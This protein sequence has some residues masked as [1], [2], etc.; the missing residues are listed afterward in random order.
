M[1][2]Y[3]L[4]LK[5]ASAELGQWLSRS[6]LTEENEDLLD[7]S[8][9]LLFGDISEWVS[10][11]IALK[12]KNGTVRKITY[13]LTNYA[14]L[15]AA[16]HVLGVGC[17]FG[18]L[19]MSGFT[20][21]QILEIVK[22]IETKV[23]KMIK[24]PLNTAI[25]FFTDAMREIQNECPKDAYN[26]LDKVIDNATK[27]FHYVSGNEVDSESFAESIKAIQ[28]LIFA[29]ITRY[30]YDEER[31]CFLPF[32]TLPLNKVNLIGQT[33]E[34]YVKKSLEQKK[35][36]TTTLFSWEST[37]EQENKIQDTL[38][39]VLKICYP[40]I[41]QARGW[42]NMRTKINPNE[43]QFTIKVMPQYLPEGPEDAAKVVVG[44][45]TGADQPCS[46]LLWRTTTHIFS[47][48]GQNIRAI[49][50][51]MNESQLHARFEENLLDI[52]LCI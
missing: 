26:T 22:R 1:S 36:V 37:L 50:Y 49:T 23:D 3:E 19:D 33:L 21:A 42:T 17:G 45:K 32:P 13:F 12:N 52:N 29:K 25:D 35:N 40:Y 38:D 34:G 18:K 48:F 2:G 44:V 47:M 10:A 4:T 41:S 39:Q 46:V 5:S 31:N 20:L 14:I 7:A 15:E 16:H 24:E 8:F 9:E 28:L 43:K 6:V 11:K 51:P 30:S 27:A